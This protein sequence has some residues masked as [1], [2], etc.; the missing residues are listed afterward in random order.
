MQFATKANGGPQRQAQISMLNPEMK[1][2]W[3]K[4]QSER[5]LQGGLCL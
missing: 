4:Q 3:S 2:T 1:L 5:R